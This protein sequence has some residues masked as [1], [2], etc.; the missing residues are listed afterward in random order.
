MGNENI[1]TKNES[2]I[3]LITFFCHRLAAG[4]PNGKTFSSAPSMIGPIQKISFIALTL[5]MHFWHSQFEWKKVSFH[6]CLSRAT[7]DYKM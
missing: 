5:Q 4:L 3:K 2:L 6:G 7:R 1:E